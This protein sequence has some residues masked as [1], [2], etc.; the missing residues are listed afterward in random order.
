[1]ICTAHRILF[2][3]SNQEWMRWAGN[4]ACMGE[5][6]GALSVL[7]RRYGWKR[8][9]EELEADRKV[10]LKWI[11]KKREGGM[12]WIDLVLDKDKWCDFVNAVVNFFFRK[13]RGIS[14]LGQNWQASQ[15]GLCCMALLVTRTRMVTSWIALVAGSYKALCKCL[16]FQDVF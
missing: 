11:L 7:V 5:R 9:L 15:E 2:G 8:P 1:M 4:V 14:C 13:V 6:W 10:L 16:M 3:W 12:K